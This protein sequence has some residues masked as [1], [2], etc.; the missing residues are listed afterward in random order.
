MLMGSLFAFIT[1]V[2]QIVFDVFK[3]PELI[4]VVFACSIAGPMALGSMPIRRLVQRFGPRQILLRALAVFVA[5][6]LVHLAVARLPGETIW[7]FVLLQALTMSCFGMIGSNAGALAHG[8]FGAYCRHGVLPPGHDHDDRRCTDRLYDRPTF[9]WHDA[10]VPDRFHDM[11]GHGTFDRLLGKS[12]RSAPADR[13]SRHGIR[14]RRRTVSAAFRTLLSSI[15]SRLRHPRRSSRLRPLPP[16]LPRMDRSIR[17]AHVRIFLEED[18]RIF[19]ALADADQIM[20]EPGADFSAIPALTPR[21]RISPIL[22]L[23][24]PY[25]MSNSTCLNGGATLF[26]TTFT[27]VALPTISSRSLIWPVR[28]GYR[29]ETDAH[30]I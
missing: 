12:R 7:T 1:S 11:R 5:V 23:P 15:R 17:S 10:A 14:R 2:Q 13:Q 28:L 4:G 19:T 22:E 18:F 26:F 21:S 3:R 16:V 20:A 27:R 24:S 6:A 9:Q 8:A 25:M 29:D 30:R